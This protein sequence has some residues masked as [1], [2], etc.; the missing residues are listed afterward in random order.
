MMF[1]SDFGS[2]AWESLKYSNNGACQPNL[3]VLDLTWP[4]VL[5]VV[6]RKIKSLAFSGRLGQAQDVAYGN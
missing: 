1:G 5:E 2:L 6:K 3:S 4:E